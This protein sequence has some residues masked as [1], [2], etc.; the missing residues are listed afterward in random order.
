MKRKLLIATAAILLSIIVLTLILTP[1]IARSYINKNGKE[2]IGRNIN[3][4]KIRINYFTFTFRIIGFKLFEKNDTSVFIKFDTLLVDLQPLKL[5]QSEL[6]VKRLWLINPVSRISKRDTVFNFSDIID[7]FSA[8]DTT[9]VKDTVPSKS[10]YKFEFSD[11]RLSKGHISYTDEDINNTTLLKNLSF[12]IPYLSWN[13]KE[14]SK[15]GLKFNFRNGGFF[16]ADGSFDPGSGDFLA[17]I[18]INNLDI[19]E[20]AGYVK[21]YIY[22]NSVGGLAGCN[23]TING[24]SNLLNSLSVEGNLLVNSFSATDKM[25]RKIL[26]M[27]TLMVSLKTSMPMADR[28]IIDSI[29]MTKPYLLFEMHDSSNNFIELLPP[30]LPDTLA[31]TNT[32]TSSMPLEY[33]VN[34]FIIREG[35]IDFTDKTLKDP[36][37]YHLSRVRLNVDSV[38]SQSNWMT[39]Y[40]TMKLNNRGD[41][42]AEI[43]INPSDPYEIKVDYVISNFQ[44]PDISPYS[45]FYLGSA[46]V[47]GNMY[48]AGKTSITARQ[49]TSDNK[50][51][52]RNAEIG[53]KSG[54]IFNLPLRLALYLIKDLNGDIKIDLPVSGDLNDPSIKIGKLIWTTFK[55]FIVKIAASPFIAIS[56]LFGVSEKDIQELDFSYQDTLLSNANAKKLDQLIQI[57]EKKPELIIELAYFND[58]T[59]EKE[60]IGLEEAGKIFLEKTGNDYTKQSGEFEAFIK[61]TLVKDTLDYFNDCIKL[62]GIEKIAAI[63]ENHDSLRV[64]LVE[65]YLKSK[66]F[67]SKIN[68]FIPNPE[69]V[70]NVGSQPVFEVKFSMEE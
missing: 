46:I 66:N 16:M 43:G 8:N 41:L 38:S 57:K 49:I 17:K 52:I 70:K 37:K 60:Q 18:I 50:L 53:K 59:K 62:A 64:R 58:R 2:L 56:N 54:G 6:A 44:L 22:L 7:F 23:L 21:P 55:N 42:K 19:S 10:D 5:I 27:D 31:E 61:S 14:S 1:H 47:Y 25:D 20:F 63:S 28:Y 30:E 39:L 51:I 65:D 12:T 40:S 48:Y 9:A 15:A 11:I 32:D 69:A 13:Q 67:A 68:I 36:F 45:K 34:S 3:L 35:I 29:S 33:S 26:G 24:N 4:E